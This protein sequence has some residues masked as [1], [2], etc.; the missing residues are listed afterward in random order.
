MKYLLRRREN[1]TP[2]PSPQV[3][4]QGDAALTALMDLAEAYGGGTP[5][6]TFRS[7]LQ[8]FLDPIEGRDARIA[9]MAAGLPD[10][11]PANGAALLKRFG[12]NLRHKLI[13]KRSDKPIGCTRFDFT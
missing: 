3:H 12:I 8:A 5:S 11:V 13:P 4:Q 9:E 1:E 7:A 10:M 6:E 2:N